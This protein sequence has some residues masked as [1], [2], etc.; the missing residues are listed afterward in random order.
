MLKATEK[1][2]EL[3][4]KNEETIRNIATLGY[5]TIPLV[6]HLDT[7]EV[8]FMPAGLSEVL[9]AVGR[10]EKLRDWSTK[11]LIAYLNSCQEEVQETPE[12]APQLYR[13]KGYNGTWIFGCDIPK[14]D[15]M[16]IALRPDSG[17]HMV[18]PKV[19]LIPVE[20]MKVRDEDELTIISMEGN[21]VV[22]INHMLLPEDIS[23]ARIVEAIKQL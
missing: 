12:E 9:V 16:C 2:L 11:D 5:H 19:R 4:R 13:I 20:R 3:I 15:H 6:K 1:Q 17:S 18:V 7:S 22:V 8:S 21:D 14:Q 23:A 10:V